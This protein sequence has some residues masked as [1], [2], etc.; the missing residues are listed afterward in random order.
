M[1]GVD[2]LIRQNDQELQANVEAQKTAW[3]KAAQ[4]S[5]RRQFEKQPAA[6][7]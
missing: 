2:T 6:K 4:E 3:E 7:I 5:R 1:A